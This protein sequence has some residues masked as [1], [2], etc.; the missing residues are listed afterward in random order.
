MCT[1]AHMYSPIV[2][3]IHAS[4]L[5][6]SFVFSLHA[7]THT[8]YL[9]RNVSV[10]ISKTTF[11]FPIV[12]FVP[13]SKQIF[14][15]SEHIFYLNKM[16][17]IE[18]NVCLAACPKQR[19]K[20]YSW[21]QSPA[22]NELSGFPLRFW[23]KIEIFGFVYGVLLS[24]SLFLSLPLLLVHVLSSPLS[25]LH[26]LLPFFIPPESHCSAVLK[27]WMMTVNSENSSAQCIT[28]NAY[29]NGKRMK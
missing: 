23:L 20:C 28:V 29:S 13:F 22:G 12:W 16:S 26:L 11:Y 6:L 1:H 5:S 3:F 8:F 18:I 17:G 19:A 4:S 7:V 10:F 21:R 2:T 27:I 9:F 24:L 14:T 25:P 15:E